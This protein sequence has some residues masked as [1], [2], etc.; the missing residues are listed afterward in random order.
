MKFLVSSVCAC[1]VAV[2]FM[3]VAVGAAPLGAVYLMTNVES[4]NWIVAH[5]IQAGG[6]LTFG[7]FTPTGGK[8]LHGTDSPPPNTPDATFSQGTVKVHGNNLFVTNPGSGSIAMFSID[9]TSPSVLTRIGTFDSGGEFPNA[10][11]ISAQTGHLCVANGG[12]VSG[13]QC[14]TID[15]TKGLSKIPGGFRTLHLTQT[16]PPLGPGGT[17]SGLLF[18]EDGSKLFV[19]V[20]GFP[21]TPGYIATFTVSKSGALSNT[22]TKSTPPNGLLPFGMSTIPGT[23]GIINADAGA[24]FTVFDFTNANTAKSAITTPLKGQVTPCWTVFSQKTQ[25]FFLTDVGAATISEVSVD[26]STLKATVVKQYQQEVN[27]ATADDDIATI[28]GNDYLYVLEGNNTSVGVLAL[29]GPGKAV[30]IQTHNFSRIAEDAGIT[31][32]PINFQGMSTWVKST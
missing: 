23:Q 5:N 17:V 3:A 1:A 9:T 6:I 18:S 32:E 27:A 30:H 14:F 24:G 19:A 25:T 26:R 15:Q 22:F 21:P 11:A 28:N 31:L 13:V 29:N 16:T 8:G 10:I 12:A 2:N 20:K 7:S 4:G